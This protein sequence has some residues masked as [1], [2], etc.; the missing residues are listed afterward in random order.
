MVIG[1][2]EAA[3]WA[4]ADDAVSKAINPARRPLEQAARVMGLAVDLGV[5]GRLSAIIAVV[6]LVEGVL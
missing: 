6:T 4:I 2:G 1:R 5:L 3:F